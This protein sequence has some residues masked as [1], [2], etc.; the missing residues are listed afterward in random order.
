METD[1]QDK[2]GFSNLG[3][4]VCLSKKSGFFY[5]QQRLGALAFCKMLS[6]NRNP[7]LSLMLAILPIIFLTFCPDS[8]EYFI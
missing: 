1:D 5:F 6:Q 2:G 8:K 3:Q 7:S 4:D